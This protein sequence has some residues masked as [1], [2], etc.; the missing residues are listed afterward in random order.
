MLGNPLV[1]NAE[2]IIGYVKP[3]ATIAYVRPSVDIVL[4]YNSKNK[5]PTDAVTLDDSAGVVIQ[6]DYNKAF[7]DS[8][9]LA[10]EIIKSV[11]YNLEF[12]ES[13]S[14]SETF[15][16]TTVQNIAETI[17]TGDTPGIGQIYPVTPTD[18]VS[19][20]DSVTFLHDG[21][22]NTNMLNTRLI[23]VGSTEVSGDDVNIELVEG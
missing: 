9:T 1:G 22:L 8:V 13:L 11:Q 21:M 17:G 14:T 10:E 19:V 7:T 5:Q 16:W 4:E 12:T 23:S 6:V 20:S 18:S 15:S 2:A 3:H